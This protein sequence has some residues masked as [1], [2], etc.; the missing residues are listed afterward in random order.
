M[1]DMNQPKLSGT[2]R[3][4]RTTIL[5]ILGFEFVGGVILSTYFY[6]FS[7][8]PLKKFYFMG[9]LQAFQQWPMWV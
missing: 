3:L 8:W 5:I 6:I 2:V 1:T 9:F 7:D 4:I